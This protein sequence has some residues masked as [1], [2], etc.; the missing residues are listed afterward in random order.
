MSLLKEFDYV[1]EIKVYRRISFK[2]HSRLN[3]LEKGFEF[4]GAK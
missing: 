1:N 4:L 2:T 3:L